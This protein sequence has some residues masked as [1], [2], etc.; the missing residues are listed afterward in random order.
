MATVTLSSKHQITL[1]VD[2][3]RSLE[4]KP[5]DKLIAELVDDHVVLLLQPDSWTDYFMG[6][7]KGVYGSTKEEIDR[8]IAEVR[9]GWEIDALKDALALDPDLRAVYEATSSQEAR[10]LSEIR[11]MSG[12]RCADQKLEELE[13]LHAVK[14]LE[15]PTQKAEPCYRRTH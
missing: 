2:M 15:H 3:V 6:S 9:H 4:L 12:V 5:G 7:M 1:P 11:D 14:R 10:S 13:K 8:Y